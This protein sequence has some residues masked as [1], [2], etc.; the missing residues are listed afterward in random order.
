MASTIHCPK[1]DVLLTE[2]YSTY[3]ATGEMVTVY[4]PCGCVEGEAMT[5]PSPSTPPGTPQRPGQ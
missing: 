4:W 1:C 5:Q 3:D 2:E